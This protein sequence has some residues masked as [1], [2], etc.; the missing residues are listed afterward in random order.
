MCHYFATS[1]KPAEV[2]VSTY[3]NFNSAL[4]NLWSVIFTEEKSE[5]AI[6][7]MGYKLLTKQNVYFKLKLRCI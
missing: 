5:I 1:Y 6:H 2:Y 4:G 7:C 3:N